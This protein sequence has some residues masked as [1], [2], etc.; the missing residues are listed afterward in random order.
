MT[1]ALHLLR[2]D[3][4]NIAREPPLWACVVLPW[5]VACALRLGLPAISDFAAPWVDLGLY[6]PHIAAF[7]LV[8]PAMMI[9]WVVGFLL[10]DER[11]ENILAAIEVTPLGRAGFIRYRLVLPTLL[12]IVTAALVH[13]CAGVL[14]PGLGP[15]AAAIVL[16]SLA[17]PLLSLFL[18]AFAANKVE[19]LALAKLGSLMAL[20]PGIWTVRVFSG[21][22]RGLAAV[23]E[24]GCGLLLGALCGLWLLRRIGRRIERT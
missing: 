20:L 6:R 16:S 18:V 12:T 1:R 24:A 22:V 2:L 5:V 7:V 21:E 19:G 10:L 15:T 13:L 3:A 17:S 11:D 8:T 14:T 9:G 23:G 4:R